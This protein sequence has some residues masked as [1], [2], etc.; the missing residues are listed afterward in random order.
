M[1]DVTTGSERV[2][3]FHHFGLSAAA[4]LL[5]VNEAHD[6]LAKLKAVLEARE[7]LPALVPDD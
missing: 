3:I 4:L 7:E 1:I 5:T 6:L 2:Q